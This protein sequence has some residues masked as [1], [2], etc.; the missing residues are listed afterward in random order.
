MYIQNK[1]IV[2]FPTVQFQRLY[3]FTGWQFSRTYKAQQKLLDRFLRPPTFD[4][5]AQHAERAG[6]SIIFNYEVLLDTL[7]EIKD[8]RGNPDGAKAAPGL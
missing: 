7:A 3:I 6:L 1:G 5:V 2:M 8:N 4:L